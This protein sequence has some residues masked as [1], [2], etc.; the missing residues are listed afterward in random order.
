MNL[1]CENGTGLFRRTSFE[2]HL[3]KLFTL[4]GAR[5]RKKILKFS[6][7]KIS[8]NN[9]QRPKWSVIDEVKVC[10]TMQMLPRDF[11]FVVFKREKNI[12]KIDDDNGRKNSWSWFRISGFEKTLQRQHDEIFIVMLVVVCCRWKVSLSYGPSQLLK[13]FHCV[14]PFFSIVSFFIL[15]KCSFFP[16]FYRLMKCR[17]KHLRAW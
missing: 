3:A 16:R 11:K 15:L 6:G 13:L 7:T 17:G 12:R 2:T 10:I 4:K 8:K 14:K 1:I 5:F 9:V